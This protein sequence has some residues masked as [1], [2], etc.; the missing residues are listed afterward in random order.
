[1][2]FCLLG[3]RVQVF[4]VMCRLLVY[5]GSVTYGKPRA[6]AKVSAALPLLQ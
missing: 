4:F 1:M 5:Y 6:W 3:R 2:A